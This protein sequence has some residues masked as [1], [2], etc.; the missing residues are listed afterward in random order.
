MA[1]APPARYDRRMLRLMNDHRAQPL[2]AAAARRLL[3]LRG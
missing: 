1:T 2:Y 3:E